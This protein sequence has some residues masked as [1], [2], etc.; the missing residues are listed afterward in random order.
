MATTMRSGPSS[1]GKVKAKEPRVRY[2]VSVECLTHLKNAQCGGKKCHKCGNKNHFSTQ[3]RPKQSGAGN[4]KS[5]STSRGCK[6]RGKPHCSRSGSK[7]VTKSAYSIESASFQDHS[8]ALHGERGDLH[9]NQR[10]NLNG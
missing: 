7:S 4:R 5:H 6:G 2:V 8:D 3:C 10:G 9:G 1:T